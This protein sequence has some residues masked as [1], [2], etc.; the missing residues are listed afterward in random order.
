MATVRLNGLNDEAIASIPSTI[1]LACFVVPLAPSGPTA[2]VS[3]R[4]NGVTVVRNPLGDQGILQ[5]EV[6]D[7][8]AEQHGPPGA[9]RLTVVGGTLETVSVE[10]GNLVQTAT[11]IDLDIAEFLPSWDAF[12]DGS[13]D[14]ALVEAVFDLGWKITG[15][16][17]RDVLSWGDEIGFDRALLFAGDDVFNGKGGNDLLRTYGGND[18]VNGGG[19][20]DRAY[21]GAGRDVVNG[22]KGKDRIFGEAGND[23]LDGGPAN[24]RLN[25]GPGNDILTGG[26]GA[27]RIKGGPGADTFMLVGL[28]NG[29]DRVLDFQDGVDMLEFGRNTEFVNARDHRDG[30]I[31]IHTGGQVILEGMELSDFSGADFL[32]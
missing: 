13:D 28:K 30:V 18:R 5:I 31:V 20:N 8:E 25:G 23:R 24:D 21:G 26:P 22:N 7:Y 1:L 32:T 29:R 15:R 4:P 3:E 12:V 16:G 2:E 9:E 17:S 14:E 10:N 11:D 6:R 19:G 27:D